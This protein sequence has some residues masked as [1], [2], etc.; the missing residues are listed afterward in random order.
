[1]AIRRLEVLGPSHVEITENL[2][3]SDLSLGRLLL[4]VMASRTTFLRGSV[5]MWLGHL[6]MYPVATHNVQS[7]GK[8]IL[9]VVCSPDEVSPV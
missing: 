5:V 4:P 8:S 1:M 9:Y 3:I 2:Q 6:E 7:S